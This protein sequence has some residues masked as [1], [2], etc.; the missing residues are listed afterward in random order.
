M[1]FNRKWMFHVNPQVL[2][3]LTLIGGKK[4][5]LPT[6]MIIIFCQKYPVTCFNFN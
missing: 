3:I 2:E 5:K 4:E 6:T 1:L